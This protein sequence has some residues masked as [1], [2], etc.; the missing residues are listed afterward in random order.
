MSK[1]II[2]I[3]TKGFTQA[4]K[5]FEDIEKSSNKATNAKNRQRQA[6]AGLRRQV[7]AL[8]NN[9]LLVSFATVGLTKALGGF[10]NASRK[11][12][13]V[14]TRLVGLTGSIKNAEVAFEAFNKVAATTPFMLD[15]VVNAGAQLQ[16]FGLNAEATLESVTDLAAFM[17]TNA[18]EAANALGRA[19]AGGAG[20]ADILRERG[21][22]NIIKTTQGLDDLSKTTLPQFRQALLKTL[23]DPA[24]GIEGSSKRMSKTLT[25][26]MSNMQDAITRFQAKVGD[27]LTPTLMKAVQA[28]EA[29]FRAIDFNDIMSFTRHV[30]ALGVALTIY[31]AKAIIAMT[32]TINFSKALRAS[33]V[34]ALA[35][36]I[37]KLLEYSGAFASN[38]AAVN[39]NSQAVQQAGMNM[40]QYISTLGQS[41]IVLER[42]NELQ[43]IQGP[44][45]NKLFLINA[46]NLG[47]DDQRLKTSQLIFDTETLLTQAFGDRLTFQKG[48]SL[49]NQELNFTVTD[50]KEGEAEFL[51][52]ITDGFQIQKQNITLNK[53]MAMSSQQLGSAFSQVGNNLRAL[54]QEGLSAEKKFAILLKTLGTVLSLTPGTAAG[55]GAISAFASLFAHTG[56]LIKNNGIQRFATGGMVQGQDNIPIMAQAGEF[57][58][59]RSAVNS[60]GLQNLAQMNNTGQPSGGVTINIAGDMVGDEDHVRTKVLP[61]IKEELRREALA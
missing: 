44:L 36:A 61:A 32:R 38:T 16:A 30:T 3:R 60:I 43:K 4:K 50:L 26:A 17:G 34:G 57:V 21:I 42:N 49:Q 53:D 9:L 15:D 23:V 25:G 13:D 7:G 18:T 52:V 33:A 31:N 55:G 10:V 47:M 40:N 2:E 8:R 19:F 48:L 27:L 39:T 51:Q 45:L 11:F 41:N 20:A 58:M 56:G 28:T 59:Q 35:F 5:G 22:L 12:E 24:S 46:Q 29:F 14:K 54:S 6:T 1:F 37:S